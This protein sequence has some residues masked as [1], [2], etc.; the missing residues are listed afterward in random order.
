MMALMVMEMA[1]RWI[2]CSNLKKKKEKNKNGLKAKVYEYDHLCFT[3]Q[4]TREG[5]IEFRID[6][7]TMKR[8]KIMVKVVI[9]CH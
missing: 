8:K 2:K 1:K 3:N 5:V 4:D 6:S 7:H 9:K